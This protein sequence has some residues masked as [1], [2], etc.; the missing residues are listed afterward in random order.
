MLTQNLSSTNNQNITKAASSSGV[1][2]TA[3]PVQSQSASQSVTSTTVSNLNN[4]NSY[5]RAV[6]A[7]NNVQ[8]PVS[9]SNRCHQQI[10]MTYQESHY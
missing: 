1:T 2:F 4:N 5:N 7:S 10:M 6:S 8:A 9:A 3:K